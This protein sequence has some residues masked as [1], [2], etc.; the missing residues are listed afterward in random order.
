MRG[1]L[2][3]LQ[4]LASGATNFSSDSAKLHSNK[5]K[6]FWF[7]RI[8]LVQ[9]KTLLVWREYIDQSSFVIYF[10]RLVHR[11]KRK[12]KRKMLSHCL[13]MIIPSTLF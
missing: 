11:N 4:R 9:T 8:C 7:I 13:M 6:G 5:C 3:L 12:E 1:D 2:F 10:F